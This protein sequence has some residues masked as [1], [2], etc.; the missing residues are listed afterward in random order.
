VA[1]VQVVTGYHRATRTLRIEGPAGSA[2]VAVSV[3]VFGPQERLRLF[4][5]TEQGLEPLM[6]WLAVDGMPKQ[7]HGWQDTFRDSNARIAREWARAGGKPGEVRLWC[8]PHMLRHS[9]RVEVVS[10]LS[11]V[12]HQR[13]AGFSA[14]EHYHA[15]PS[16]N[17]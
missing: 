14:E 17:R 5:R 11:V 13:L 15:A 16:A 9:F 4:R 8:R 3:D 6:V 7:A 2:A 10:I 1:G 12:W